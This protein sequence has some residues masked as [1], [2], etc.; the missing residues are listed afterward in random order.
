VPD[1]VAERV[2]VAIPRHDAYHAVANVRRLV[3]WSPEC[4]AYWVRSGRDG[5]LGQRWVGF[6]RR[7]R[8]VWFTTSE[9][10]V[11]VPGEEFAFDVS[12]FGQPV[13]R[14][15]YR[16]AAVEGGTEI[17]EL[18][19]GPALRGRAGDG[20]PVHR[21]GRGRPAAGQR[22]G[23]AHHVGPPQAGAG[24]SLIQRIRSTVFLDR[25]ITVPAY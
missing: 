4:F 12:A 21:P 7:G 24:G 18:L 1:E 14:W 11:A 6:N 20:P 9:V 17:T 19:A 10:V 15:G 16:F 2:T 3:R 8:Y 23:H 13:S 22:G 5:E 25:H